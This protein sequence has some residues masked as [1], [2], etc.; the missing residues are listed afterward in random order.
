MYFNT[1]AKSTVGLKTRHLAF[2]VE[3]LFL[4][5]LDPQS[6]WVFLRAY[7]AYGREVLARSSQLTSESTI[8]LQPISPVS[9]RYCVDAEQLESAVE[10]HLIYGYTDV[11]QLNSEQLRDFLEN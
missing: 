5:R 6:I 4:H 10:C 11:E 7:D 3:H 8:P 9:I 1:P 2:A